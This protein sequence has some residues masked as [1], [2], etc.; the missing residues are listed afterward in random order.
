MSKRKAPKENPNSEFCDF[1]IELADFEKNV[2]RNTFKSKAYRK[3]ASVLASHPT[4]IT[5]GK[6]A[7]KLDGIGDKIGKKIDEFIKSG[8]LQKLEKIRASSSNVSI[9]ELTRVPGIGPAAAKKFVEDGISSIADLRKNTEKLNHHQKIGLKYL[10]DF[11]SRIPRSEMMLH[12][13]FVVDAMSSFDKDIQV[14]ICGSY[15]RGAESSGDIDVLVAHPDFTSQTKALGTPAKENRLKRII[16]VLEKS[17]YIKDTISHGDAKFMGVCKLPEDGSK[18]RHLDV[19]LIPFDQ[20]HFGVLFFTGS[21]IFNQ[22]MR[23]EALEKGFTLNEY[24]IR[25][26]GI[27]G[28]PG[29]AIAAGSER[30]IFEIIGKDYVKPIDRNL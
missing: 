4:R 18:H 13:K 21:D 20:Y 22:Q 5:S 8:T 12:E 19:R 2:E 24:C 3:A 30:E 10:D 29:E 14:S 17:G 27:S 1:L 7:Q 23:K 26:L 6:E 28:T 11:E 9:K 15:R 16:G 25:P